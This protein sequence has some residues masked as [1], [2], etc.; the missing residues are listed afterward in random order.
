MG[1]A[2]GELLG[3]KEKS[4]LTYLYREKVPAKHLWRLVADL[5]ARIAAMTALRDDIRL[6]QQQQ[7]RE[8]VRRGHWGPGNEPLAARENRL[9]SAGL[10][11]RVAGDGERKR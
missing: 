6:A 9:R 3:I 7:D 11:P 1:R 5:D 10:L 4:A 8:I 2:L